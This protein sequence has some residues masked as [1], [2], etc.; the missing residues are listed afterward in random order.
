MATIE[1]TLAEWMTRS[2]GEGCHYIQDIFRET[3][4]ENLLHRRNS[5]LLIRRG[6]LVPEDDD[7]RHPHQRAWDRTKRYRLA[8]TE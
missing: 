8:N 5:A 1:E 7:G 2:G 6:R 4:P 3:T